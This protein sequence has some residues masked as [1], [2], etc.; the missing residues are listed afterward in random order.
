MRR[1]NLTS[2]R[3]T[4]ANTHPWSNLFI[5][6]LLLPLLLPTLGQWWPHSHPSEQFVVHRRIDPNARFS[7]DMAL[8][9]V[10]RSLSAGLD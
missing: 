1:A 5:R 10:S 8:S 9:Q 4:S 3:R 7:I 2:P 6:L